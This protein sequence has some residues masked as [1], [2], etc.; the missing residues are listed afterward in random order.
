MLGGL[1][2]RVCS[3]IATS[4]SPGLCYMAIRT[5]IILYERVFHF[6]TTLHYKKHY[7]Y[8]VSMYIQSMSYLQQCRFTYQPDL[9]VYMYKLYP[10]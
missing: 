8:K 5:A 9:E 3:S 7:T 2:T 1:T 10:R 4:E 6:D